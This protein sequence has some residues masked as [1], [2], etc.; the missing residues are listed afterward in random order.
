MN[1]ISLFIFAVVVVG[2]IYVTF[3]FVKKGLKRYYLFVLS[4]VTAV[5]LINSGVVPKSITNDVLSSTNLG[6]DKFKEKIQREDEV[7][8]K[9]TLTSTPKNYKEEGKTSLDNSLN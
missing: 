1:L 2:S 4:V 6:G 5:V 9:P 7:I 3:K 8:V